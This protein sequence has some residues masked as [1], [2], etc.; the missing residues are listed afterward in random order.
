MKKYLNREEIND[1]LILLDMAGRMRDMAEGW[2]KRGNLPAKEAGKLK[3]AATYME[4]V[5]DLI[6]SCLPR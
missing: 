3:S 1:V 2:H 5:G 4:K 6:L